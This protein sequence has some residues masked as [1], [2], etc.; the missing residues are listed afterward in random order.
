MRLNG[1][2]KEIEKEIIQHVL[3]EENNNQSKAAD[4][5]GIN[6]ATLWRKLKE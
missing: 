4:R 1:T 6:R 2:L 5:L 3:Q